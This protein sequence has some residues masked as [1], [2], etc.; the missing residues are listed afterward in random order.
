MSEQRKVVTNSPE[1]SETPLDSLQS[2]VTPTRLFFV[3]N[4]FEPPT[5][6]PEQWSLEIGGLVNNPQTLTLADLEAL[7]QHTLF[8]TLECAGNGRSYLSPRAKGV[9]W[10]AG[11]IAHA[12]WTG[13]PL[14]EILDKLNIAEDAIEIIFEG[15]DEGKEGKLTEPIHFARGLPLEK[16][17]HPD[18]ML[19]L[20]MNGEPLTA[21]HGAPVR[22]LVPGWYGMA[23]V[24]WLKRME[25]TNTPFDGYYQ[26]VKY[27]INK[28]IDG[29]VK[30]VGIQQMAVKSQIIRPR[31]DENLGVGK[32]RI[33]GTAWAG[34]S[35]VA[36]VDVSTDNG[37]TWNQAKLIGLQAPYSWTLWEFDW[38][39]DIPGE[40]SLLCRATSANGETQPTEHDPLLGGYI[41][42]FPLPQKVQVDRA[43]VAEAP[44]Y[45]EAEALLYDLFAF[46]EENVSRPLDVNM[47]LVDGAGI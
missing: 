13:V 28:S 32:Q 14:V 33:F 20:R 36:R 42:N 12:E 21:E 1:N 31:Q 45:S 18:T 19:A 4:H 40:Y 47:D 38:K 6:D 9:Q 43:K 26:T 22:L 2:W 11:A 8:V 30:T 44:Q 29:E 27:T 17:R 23:S 10:A 15:A 41:I 35:S 37:I 34:E 25:F 16:A 5:I 7:P 46:A 3:R 24:K 39:V